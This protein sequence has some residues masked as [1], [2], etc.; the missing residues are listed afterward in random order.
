MRVVLL[1]GVHS[2]PFSG[3]AEVSHPAPGIV[4]CLGARRTSSV[5]VTTMLVSVSRTGSAAAG[6]FGAP[7]AGG[8]R[9]T[10][11]S[12]AATLVG[13][14]TNGVADIFIFEDAAVVPDEA[15]GPAPRASRSIR[16]ISSTGRVASQ[17]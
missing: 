11:S 14:D 6:S 16:P 17:P 13:S 12:T 4:L 5:V 10:F 15:T 9:V 2:A 3:R 7:A 8:N 1:K